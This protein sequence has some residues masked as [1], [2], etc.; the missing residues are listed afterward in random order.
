MNPGSNKKGAVSEQNGSIA[1]MNT[2]KQLNKMETERIA[3]D[4][5]E[6]KDEETSRN[7]ND[8]ADL[9][10]ELL[11]GGRAE[12][13]ELVSAEVEESQSCAKIGVDNLLDSTSAKV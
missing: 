7:G 6:P 5:R 8:S 13:E 3:T 10:K 11:A 12:T 1:E 4:S 2:Q 9:T